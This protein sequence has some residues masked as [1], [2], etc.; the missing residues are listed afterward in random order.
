LVCKARADTQ[1]YDLQKN[2]P[3]IIGLS[4]YLNGGFL[5]D[6]QTG[7]AI[8]LNDPNG[9]LLIHKKVIGADG[10]IIISRISNDGRTLWQLNTGV[11]KWIDYKFT[12][13]SLFIFANDNK[14][15]SSS[16]C[17]VFMVVDCKSGTVNKYDYF[18]DAMRK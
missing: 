12:G 6:K 14:E 8:Q 7:K 13:N 16:E 18:K 5:A 4:S 3:L 11:S 15:V 17:G 9:Y 1:Q 10:E 2:C